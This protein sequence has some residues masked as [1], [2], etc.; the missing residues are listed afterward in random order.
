MYIDANDL[1]YSPDVLTFSEVVS[2]VTSFVSV[3][4]FFFT[5][6]SSLT[7]GVFVTSPT[8]FLTGIVITSLE[9]TGSCACVSPLG[10][11]VSIVTSS[12]VNG[13]STFLVSFT[14]SLVIVA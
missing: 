3:I 2:S 8:S 1:Y 10:G 9:E 14:G 12:W 5:T 7:Y 13:T 11:L 6:T 4:G